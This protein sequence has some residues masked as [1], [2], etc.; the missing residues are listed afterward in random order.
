MTV[1][2]R[3][4]DPAIRTAF[5]HDA[6]QPFPSRPRR[7]RRVREDLP[8]AA[9]QRAQV[10]HMRAPALILGRDA[11]QAHRVVVSVK[12]LVDDSCERRGKRD[13]PIVDARAGKLGI[14]DARDWI[15]QFLADRSLAVRPDHVR[16]QRTDSPVAAGCTQRAYARRIAVDT[17]PAD[18]RSPPH[19]PSTRSLPT[20]QRNPPNVPSVGERHAQSSPPDEPTAEANIRSTRAKVRT[21]QTALARAN[22][23][24]LIELT[25]ERDWN[26]NGLAARRRRRSAR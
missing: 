5:T 10:L 17:T 15:A 13:P 23:G 25:I 26:A 19:T 8:T 6:Q 20:T 22:H 4:L 14:G 2:T 1:R 21:M 11:Y 18:A 16:N 12:Q 7:E 9:L 3:V 24:E